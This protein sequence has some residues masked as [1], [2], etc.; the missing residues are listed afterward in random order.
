MEG[1][2]EAA[3]PGGVQGFPGQGKHVSEAPSGSRGA[4]SAGRLRSRN[5]LCEDKWSRWRETGTVA[6]EREGQFPRREAGP[7]PGRAPH[8][9]RRQTEGAERLPKR[10][11]RLRLA[12]N[13]DDT[14]VIFQK[15]NCPGQSHKGPQTPG[16]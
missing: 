16:L 9:V 1:L 15:C 14:C 13:W 6:T 5:L 10:I 11:K 2:Q 7:G 12:R 3:F 4:G 8:K